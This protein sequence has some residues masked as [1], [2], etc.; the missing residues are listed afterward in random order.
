M[1]GVDRAARHPGYWPSAWPVECGGNRRQKAATG[2]LDASAGAAA[3]TTRRN[4]RWNVM[5]VEREPGQWYLGG[6]MASFSGPR[7]F[8]WVE[9][10]DPTTLEPLAA[11]AE[12]PCGDH[13]WCGAILAHAN[14]SIYSVNGSYLHRLDPDDLS[15]LAE[16]RLPV[17][18]SH[19]GLLALADGTLITKDLRL[20]GQGGTTLTRVDPETL[21]LVHDPVVLAEPSMGRIAA[22]LTR[23]GAE[24][25]YVPGAEHVWRLTTHDERLEVDAWKPRYRQPRDAWGLAWDCC[26]SADACWVMDCGDVQSVRRIHSVEPN[27]RFAD[28][29]GRALSWRLP[30]PWTGAQRLLRISLTESESDGVRWIEPFG[31]PGGGIIAPPVHVAEHDMA[32]AWDSVNGG[33]AGI[34]TRD[35]ALDVVWHLAIR[36]SMQPVVFPDSGEL[37]I[38]DYTDGGTDDIVIVDVATGALID[39]CQTGSR[40]GNGMFLSPDGNRGLFYCSTLTI[41]HVTWA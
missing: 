31:T 27:G 23:S 4:G 37:A 16:R 5:T 34:R 8:G 38:N 33:L 26:L 22:D 17:D 41:A 40:I 11:S 19:N 14:G 24:Y 10:I 20:E 7:P 29:P 21:D 32:V 25:V 28:P 30:A 36:P 6:T 15:V 35:G 13:V 1:T 9:R 39:R 2:R 3:V 18:R 12:L